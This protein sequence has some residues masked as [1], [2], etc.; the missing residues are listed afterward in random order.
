[1]KIEVGKDNKV[2]IRFPYD[3]ELIKRIKT[4]LAKIEN[5]LDR[6]IDEGE[7]SMSLSKGMYMCN[8]ADLND[9]G[10][11]PYQKILEAHK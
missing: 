5:P 2:I 7:R 1:M 3:Q 4:N 8:T 10:E 9:L 11:M 6:M